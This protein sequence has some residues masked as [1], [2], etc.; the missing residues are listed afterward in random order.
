MSFERDRRGRYHQRPSSFW[1]AA[2]AL[3]ALSL[4][5][6][7]ILISSSGGREIPRPTLRLSGRCEDPGYAGGMILPEHISLSVNF[8]DNVPARV[9]KGLRIVVTDT[10]TLESSDSDWMGSDGN[11]PQAFNFNYA[12]FVRKKGGEELWLRQGRPLR[13]GVF[14]AASEDDV[15]QSQ[16]QPVAQAEITMDC[17]GVPNNPKLNTP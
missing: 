17:P 8:D 10:A 1:F 2:V 12:G 13:V 6:V 9:R 11:S 15:F 3:N 16:N 4:A 5:T 14:D 7:I